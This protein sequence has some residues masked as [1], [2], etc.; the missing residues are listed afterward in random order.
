MRL[1]EYV[2]L[3]TLEDMIEQRYVSAQKHP[4]EPLEILNYTQR[5]Q[6]DRAWNDVTRKCRGLIYDYETG[7]V[8]A[9][10]WP[11]FFNLAEPILNPDGSICE[12]CRYPDDEPVS[13]YDKLDGSLGILYPLPSGGNAIATRGS[14]VSEQAFHATDL[15]NTRYAGTRVRAGWTYLFEIVYPENR[16]VCDYGDTD[17]LFFLGCVEVATGRDVSVLP[18]DTFPG[19]WAEEM[20]YRTLADALAAEPRPNAEGYVVTFSD[21]SK[22]KLKQ[23]D[24]IALHRIMT[25]LNARNV[26]EVAAVAA[27]ADY[28]AEPK[29]WGSYLGIDPAR[30][31]E[32]AALGQD[33][34]DGVPD[35]FH[36]WVEQVFKDAER[37]AGDDYEATLA[38]A[39]RI[40]AIAERAERYAAAA[41]HPHVRELMRISSATDFPT[42]QAARNELYLRCWRDA[43][44]EPTAP[45][46]R[47]EAIA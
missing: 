17:D 14:F 40:S 35:E 15:W 41:D 46:A 3:L 44:P 43:C 28:I 12:D 39:E 2:D 27:C 25:G 6:F 16:V 9:R 20:R 47:S 18:G 33:W 38:F 31:E 7:L 32:C 1:G 37:V 22:V 19:P 11:K 30:A 21:G 45:F 13:V 36:A 23:D 42:A 29:H 26:W 24:Y 8:V 4:T 34:L 5:C 10:P